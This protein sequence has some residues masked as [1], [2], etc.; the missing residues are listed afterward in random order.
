MQSDVGESIVGSYLR[1][2]EK[3]DLVLY[4]EFTGENQGEVDVIGVKVGKE[5]KVWLCEVAT[6]IRGLQYRQNF[7]ASKR[8]IMSKIDRARSYA[9]RVFEGQEQRFELWSPYVPEGQMTKWMDT[10]SKRLSTATFK[11]EFV[12]NDDYA[13]RVQALIDEARMTASTTGEPAFRMLQILT[14]VRGELEL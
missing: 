3:C 4:N 9:D 8:T 5:P 13:L 2:V 10:T 12:R 1:H 6:H 14:R 7:D 11:V